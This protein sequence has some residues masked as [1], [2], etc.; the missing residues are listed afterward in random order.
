MNQS[1]S[2]MEHPLSQFRYC[3]KCGSSILRY[4]M[5]NPNNAPIAGLYYFNPRP[6]L[7]HWFLNEKRIACMPPGKG[8]KGAWPPRW[9]YWYEWNRRRRSGPWSTEETGLK[10]ENDLSVYATEHLRLFD[11]RFTL[12]MFFL[13]I[14]IPIHRRYGRCSWCILRSSYGN[15]P[16]RFPDWILSGKGLDMFIHSNSPSYSWIR[17]ANRQYFL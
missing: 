2:D 3:P 9:I 4:I 17:P 10:V 11:S 15:T 12:D 8:R 13:C 14:K 6:P 7:L 1:L 16:G 5:R